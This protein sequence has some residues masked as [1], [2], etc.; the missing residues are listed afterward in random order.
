MNWSMRLEGVGRRYGLTGPWVLRDVDMEVGA[1]RLLRLE[2][3]NGSGKSTLLRLLAGIDRPSAG[4]ISGRPAR[5]AYV[6]ERFPASLP[7]TALG[8]LTH[9]GRVQGL[10]GPGA[11]RAGS[12]WLDRFGAG[13]YAGTRMS[14]LSKGSSQKV[15][16]AQ[17]L[18]GEPELLLLDEAWT[19]LDEGARAALDA[20]VGERVADGGSVVFVDH[21]PRRLGE[22]TD[23]VHR[24]G[25]GGL[26]PG[27]GGGHDQA[28]GLVRIEAEGRPGEPVE[29]V[30][31]AR[32]VRA[33][34]D[35]VAVLTVPEGDSDA[36]LYALLG[37]APGM[38]HVRSVRRVGRGGRGG[39]EHE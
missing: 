20:A 18:L 9:L 37:G 5:R 6:P 12:A 19:G 26:G 15:A 3:T 11:R 38:W 39:G 31:G 25:D 28:V 10:S 4:R 35:G 22:V 29:G 23:A 24:V 34:D 7:L 1:G 17:A 33:G 13:Q 2:G 36:V 30:R 32:G 8:Y 16:V 21:D 27:A 14:E